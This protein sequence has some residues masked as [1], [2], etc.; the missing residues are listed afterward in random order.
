ML[1]CFF[2]MGI[3]PFS[4]YFLFNQTTLPTTK[5]KALDDHQLLPTRTFKAINM[6]VVRTSHVI[7][8]LLK[9]SDS[10]NEFSCNP[11]T[12]NP[13]IFS[14]KQTKTREKMG[15]CP[16]Q[17]NNPVFFPTSQTNQENAPLLKLDFLKIELLKKKIMEPYSAVLRSLQ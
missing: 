17:K 2:E 4:P 16:F 15:K 6:I 7:Q 10:I 8:L 3:C 9:L 1:D 5:I 11:N 14:K 12:F 13:K